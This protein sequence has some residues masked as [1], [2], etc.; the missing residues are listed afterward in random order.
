MGAKKAL[1]IID[2][3]LRECECAEVG[4]FI[5]ILSYDYM[6]L[7]DISKKDFIKSLKNSLEKIE[8]R[9]PDEE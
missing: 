7:Y 8:E 5:S 1:K 4:V 2:K 9:Q 6:C 3:I